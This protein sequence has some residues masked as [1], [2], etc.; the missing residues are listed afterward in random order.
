M[1]NAVGSRGT[2][3]VSMNVMMIGG[4]SAVARVAVSSAIIPKNCN[5]LTSRSS[6]K[7]VR[8]IRKP[9]RNV[10]SLLFEP[11]DCGDVIEKAISLLSNPHQLEVMGLAARQQACK[12]SQK[13][14]CGAYIQLY[15]RLL[16]SRVKPIFV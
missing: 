3:W 9:S 11:D 10:D 8:R 13:T 7:I 14:I 12:F 5:G 4:V 6:W 1:I 15:G 16:A 2:V